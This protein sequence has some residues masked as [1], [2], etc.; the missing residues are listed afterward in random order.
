MKQTD[1]KE[2]EKWIKIWEKAG[3]ALDK[4]KLKELRA[5]D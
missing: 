5:V 1:R 4:V 2:I 3:S